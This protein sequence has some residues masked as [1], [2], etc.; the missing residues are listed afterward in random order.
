MIA[1]TPIPLAEG[2]IA[3]GPTTALIGEYTGAK[4]NPEVVAPLDKLK[5]IIG[6]NEGK[7]QI[8]VFG[9]IDGNDIVLTNDLTTQ[10]RLR[11]T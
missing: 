2:G 4:N 3:F 11:Y 7:Q 8:E 9:R 5:N 1:S 10:K 6:N